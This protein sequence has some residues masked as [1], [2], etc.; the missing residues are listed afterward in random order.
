[1]DNKLALL[2]NLTNGFN[3]VY[4]QLDFRLHDNYYRMVSS[5]KIR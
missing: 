2:T 5:E 1:M 4:Y 3:L